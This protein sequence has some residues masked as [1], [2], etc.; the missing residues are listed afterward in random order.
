MAL[1]M[2]HG[3]STS[4]HR[5]PTAID[6]FSGAGGLSLGLR[7]ARFRV[8]AALDA[9]SLAVESY[10]MNFPGVPVLCN[11]IRGVAASDLLSLAKLPKYELDLLAGCPPCQGFS[12]LRTKGRQ[13]AVNDNRNGLILEFLRLVREIRPRYVLME[14]VPGLARSDIF[15]RF[16]GGL[17][18]T[19]YGVVSDVLDSADFGAPQHRRRLVLI[20]ERDS[21]PN[22]MAGGKN[23]STVRDSIAKLAGTA[24][25]SGD[26]LHDHGELRAQRVQAIIEAIPKNGGSRTDLGPDAQLECH[27]RALDRG[28]GWGRS[29]YGRMSWDNPAPAITTGCVNPSKGRFIHPDENRAIT[30][31][32]ALLLQG[33]PPTYRLSLRRGKSAAADLIGNA[34]PPSFVKEQALALR[35]KLKNSCEMTS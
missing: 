19:G 26:P 28:D 11:D 8:V 25:Q 29:P 21:Q 18:L 32:E 22:L 1:I 9:S 5:W 31:R 7:Q 34:V 24:G 17:K 6:L 12:A 13:A 3:V 16:V 14:N 33:F 27:K 23:L 35:Y 2:G 10:R 30:L 15:L 4:S 20:A